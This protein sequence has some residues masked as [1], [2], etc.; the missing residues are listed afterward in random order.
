[1]E[2]NAYTF[3][4]GLGYDDIPK[5]ED[6][7]YRKEIYRTAKNAIFKQIKDHTDDGNDMDKAYRIQVKILDGMN[8]VSKAEEIPIHE[9]VL[10]VP[11]TEN[12]LYGI[13]QYRKYNFK[14]RL[15]ILFKGEL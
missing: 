4:M 14:E 1:M 15:K 3:M 12:E 8:V 9:V 5:L 2:N 7:N 13:P 11:K 10:K 6:I